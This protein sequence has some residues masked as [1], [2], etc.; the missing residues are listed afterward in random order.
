MLR[1]TVDPPG[2]SAYKPRVSQLLARPIAWLRSRLGAT[3]W[4]FVL[5]IG[6]GAAAGGAA[7]L[8]NDAIGAVQAA[9]FGT[10]DAGGPVRHLLAA[11]PGGWTRAVLAPT[12]GG[13]LVGLLWR[14]LREPPDAG[15]PGVLRAVQERGGRMSLRQALA[16]AAASAVSLGAGLSLGREGPIVHLGASIA[17]VLGRFGVTSS[18]E[19]RVLAACGAGAGLGAVFDAPLGGAAFALEVVVGTI[20][21]E[22]CGPVLVATVA[23]TALARVLRETPVVAVPGYRL[24]HP[25]ELAAYL[26]LGVLAGVLAA[27][28]VRLIREAIVRGDAL[29]GPAW[30]RPALGG[31][32]VGLIAV[33]FSPR[34]LGN[35]YETIDVLLRSEVV[36]TSLLLLLGLKVLATV[37]SVGAGGA[38]GL[39]G[40]SIFL[41]AV[42]GAALGQAVHTVAP[43]TAPGA[44]ALVGMAA[45]VAGTTHAPVCMVLMLFELTDDYGVVLALLASAPVAS[46][47]ARR[48]CPES[49][50][51]VVAA[52]R[53]RALGAAPGALEAIR[54]ADVAR[55]AP[56]AIVPPSAPLAQVLQTFLRA[57]SDVVIVGEQ[58]V[59]GAILLEDVQ[60]ALSASGAAGR[61]IIAHDVMREDVPRL[62]ADDPLAR[63]AEAFQQ[64]SCGTLPV[65][66]AAGALVGLIDHR[67]LV[68]ALQTERLRADLV[69][70]GPADVAVDL[71]VDA[72]LDRIPAPAWLVGRS[73][74][75]LDLR[76]RTGVQVV[77][78][79][80]P[81]PAGTA[82]RIP[83]PHAPVPQ[84]AV[85]VVV[86]P[87]A[88]ID[89][90]RRG[91]A[92]ADRP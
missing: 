18:R 14:V 66:D 78:L 47:V 32:C 8:L 26:L 91:D 46:T 30:L 73:L 44:F 1:P 10:A 49:I 52:A 54:L 33:A 65:L 72:T 16:C 37:V 9:S 76:R 82:T 15:V 71:G 40:P 38:G 35:G 41:G 92:P 20:A 21:L 90:L 23:G 84:D 75:Q 19:L 80:A 86:G 57:R 69:G 81:G 74:A 55:P 60:S 7:M 62:S 25:A 50:D 6:A 89:A 88:A 63:A 27:G 43:G 24:G 45:V 64:V 12:L 58:R 61:H 11:G 53:G 29:P 56:E 77:A 13:L 28:L 17:S 59:E 79:R 3:A 83:D 48:L 87:P 68:A 39:F 22:A 4:L 34:V 67:P 70:V 85:L 42:L 36:E 31:L 5:A 51:T 2:A